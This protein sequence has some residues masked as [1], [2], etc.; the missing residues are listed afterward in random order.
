VKLPF[1]AA[2]TQADGFPFWRAYSRISRRGRPASE[3]LVSFYFRPAFKRALSAYDR[4]L[5]FGPGTRTHKARPS[6]FRNLVRRVAL[7]DRSRRVT[8]PLKKMEP[9]R[10]KQH[11]SSAMVARATVWTVHCGLWRRYISRL[12]NY[13]R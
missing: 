3:E 2:A 1:E 13:M 4:R 10:G 11:L 9:S 5:D 8:R 6:V 7:P 12:T